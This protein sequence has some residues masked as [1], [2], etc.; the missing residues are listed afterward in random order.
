MLSRVWCITVTMLVS[1]VTSHMANIT[2]LSYLHAGLLKWPLLNTTPLKGAENWRLTVIP[3]F[4]HV[5][6]S[7]VMVGMLAGPPWAPVTPPSMRRLWR[8]DWICPR[9]N[10]NTRRSWIMM[11]DGLVVDD[12][13]LKESWVW[14]PERPNSPEL[15]VGQWGM[16]EVSICFCFLSSLKI[17]N[18]DKRYNWE[19]ISKGMEVRLSA[20]IWR[21]VS[22]AAFLSQYGWTVL[23]IALM[24]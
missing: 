20:E 4:S 11:D 21:M 16:L 9:E 23:Q 3:V 14:L 6:S 17:D 18:W 22:W 10:W 24:C 13:S 5:T 12:N 2:G 15:R 1:V 19:N 8:R 7:P